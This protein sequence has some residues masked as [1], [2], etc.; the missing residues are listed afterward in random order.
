VS[1][2]SVV[3][4][5][6]ES[7]VVRTGSFECSDPLLNRIAETAA[8]TVELCVRRGVLWDGIKRDRL[9]WIGDIYPEVLALETLTSDLSSVTRSLDFVKSQTPP[10][11]WM[12]NIPDYSMWWMIIL[13]E[14]YRRTGDK[15]YLTAQTDYIEELLKNVD[16]YIL[17]DGSD[18]FG[19]NLVD[20]PTHETADEPA[21]V[22]MLT[23]MGMNAAEEIL[24]ATG[25]DTALCREI[26]AR[27]QRKQVTVREKKQ[28][29]ALKD[30]TYGSL[31]EAEKEILTTGG[32]SGMSTFMS[33][34]LLRAMDR[35]SG[36]EFA[37]TVAKDY[38]GAML[39]LGATSFWEDFNTE[40]TEGAICPI[41][42]LPADGE[43]DIHGDFGA[44]C[45]LGYRHSLCHGWSS[46][47]LPY[48][49]EKV[50][51]VT[52]CDGGNTVVIEPSLGGLEWA[53]GCVPLK[54]GLLSV[55]IR[56]GKTKLKAP[57]GVKVVCKSRK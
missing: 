46:G 24:N 55:E 17:E 4:E 26:K 38:Y 7:E 39:N 49:V 6:H 50:L 1:F 5:A 25:R 44:Y 48:L 57:A 41:D 20:W 10:W 36:T 23:V 32:A 11:K 27:L 53:K 54:K 19:F 14:Y 37:L 15:D 40:W 12:N 16:K 34:F 29:V 51:G 42:R 45:Y 3:A 52:V 18:S 56:D 30:F 43:K 35:A 28:I 9:V 8:R 47:V 13:C 22:H 33:Y 2:K 21:G 31:S